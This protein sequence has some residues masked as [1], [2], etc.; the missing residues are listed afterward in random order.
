[1][2][3]MTNQWLK[4]SPE[5]NRGHLP[6]RVDMDLTP[7]SDDWSENHGV[8]GAITGRRGDG[9]YQSV[10]FEKR[11][12]DYLLPHL[13]ESASAGT[14]AKI[15]LNFVLDLDD[16]DFLGFMARLLTNRAK[17]RRSRNKPSTAVPKA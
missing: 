14:K 17:I 16:E 11:D 15:V 7:T 3:Y 13:V 4:G 9:H 10:Y 8:V 1:V 2:G 5:R 12:L 6:A